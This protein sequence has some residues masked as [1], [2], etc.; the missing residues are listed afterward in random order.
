MHICDLGR[1]INRTPEDDDEIAAT[2]TPFIKVPRSRSTLE[3]ACVREGAPITFGEVMAASND[4]ETIGCADPR[5]SSAAAVESSL[6]D[7]NV[8]RISSRNSRK[9]KLRSNG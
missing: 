7:I 5:R 4:V 9:R 3:S 2:F 6:S 8:Q 1:H